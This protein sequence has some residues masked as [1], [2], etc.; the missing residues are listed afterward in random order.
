MTCFVNILMTA[1][2]YI[3]CVPHCNESN[4]LWLLMIYF[5]ELLCYNCFSFCCFL[6]QISFEF[7]SFCQITFYNIC[8]YK[9][10]YK[11]NWQKHKQNTDCSFYLVTVT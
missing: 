10:T 5:L 4:A 7:F 9:D 8:I 11:G 3:L 1:S 2:L 6:G